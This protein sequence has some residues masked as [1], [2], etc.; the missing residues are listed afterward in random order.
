MHIDMTHNDYKSLHKIRSRWQKEQQLIREKYQIPYNMTYTFKSCPT[1]PVSIT[2]Q[3]KSSFKYEK[4]IITQ[5]SRLDEHHSNIPPMHCSKC[6][7]NL[8]EC[9][10]PDGLGQWWINLQKR[11]RFTGIDNYFS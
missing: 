8:T 2:L 10:C 1:K 5:I 6:H 3:D 4:N 11:T 7:L 9:T